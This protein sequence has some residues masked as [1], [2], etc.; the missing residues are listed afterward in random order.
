MN[1]KTA[2]RARSTDPRDYQRVARPFAAMAKGF[3]DGFEIAPHHHTRDQLIYAVSG[4]MRVRTEHEAWIVP[5]DRA[6]Y[7]PGRT[8]HSI[9]MR[10]GVEMRTLYIARDAAANLPSGATVMAVSDLLREL[11]LALIDEP[12]L[13]D[14]DGRGGAIVALIRSE[15]MRAPRLPLVIPMPRDPRL[16]HLCARLIADPSDT[17]TLDEWSQSAGA[18]ARTLARLFESELR[19]TF[20]AWR[21]RVRFHNAL[22]A[23][24]QG[25]PVERIAAANG[26]RSSS[27][28]SAAFRAIMGHAPTAFSLQGA[29]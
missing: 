25:Q 11:I 23:I 22:E 4:L 3:A 18:S 10:G 1:T 8:T 21:Q 26:Y 6:V 29:R 16:R 12:L 17:R 2:S 15:I 24:A 13:Y 27:A 20:T 7:V 5:P 9:S 28:F 14:K 19:L